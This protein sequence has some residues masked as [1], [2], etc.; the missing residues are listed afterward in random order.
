MLNLVEAEYTNVVY[1]KKAKFRFDEHNI[2]FVRGLNLDA[3]PLSPTGNGA[4]KSLLLGCPSNIF[5]FSPPLAIKKK[6]KK[7]L[8]LKGSKIRIVVKNGDDTFDVTQE[9]NKYT[10]LK[11][12]VDTEIRTVPLAEKL[13]REQIFTLSEL[14]YYTYGFVS[15]QKPFKMQSDSD[16]DRLI[17]FTA[18]FHLDNY[19][20]LRRHFLDK[21][22]ALKDSELT[23]QIYEKDHLSFS[24]KLKK[25]QTSLN[26]NIDL[27]AL[28][29][30][31]D[32]LELVITGLN[33]KEYKLRGF[34]RDLEVYS[35]IEEELDELRAKYTA[36]KAP[37]V[38]IKTLK[39]QRKLMR[40]YE[41][42]KKLFS[43]Y[44]STIKEASAKLKAL[45]LPSK[46][47]DELKLLKK[48][49][50]IEIDTLEH[51]IAD[52]KLELKQIARLDAELDSIVRALEAVGYKDKRPDLKVDH[53]EA[54]AALKTTLRL[55]K[56]IKHSHENKEEEG[57]CPTCLSELDIS[58]ISKMVEKAEK[59]LPKLEAEV[60]AQTKYRERKEIEKKRAVY[61]T[62]PEI[63]KSREEL[64]TKRE[65]N[66]EL[67]DAQ[68][69]TWEKHKSLTS[70]I[71]SIEKPEVVEK[72][73]SELTVD[74]FDAEIELCEEITK[75]L[76]SKEKLLE[77]SKD[78]S[79]LRGKKEVAI[80]ITA[81]K[82]E[83]KQLTKDLAHQKDLL[84]AVLREL[85]SNSSTKHECEVY[86]K[87]LKKLQGQISK[88]KPFIEDKQIFQ[89][90]AKAYSSKGL[91]TKV[92]NDICSLLEQN[93]NAY[94]SLIF[95][96]P[97]LFTVNASDK[98]ISILVDR[99]NGKISDVR[100][101]SGAESN[102]F[103]LLFV[104][105]LLPLVPDER[106]LN[107]LMLDEPC[108]H[109]DEISR[110][111]FLSIFL[112]ALAELVPNIFIITPNPE[113]YCEGS[114]DWIVKKENGKSILQKNKVQEIDV[115]QI[116]ASAK[117][118]ITKSRKSK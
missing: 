94:S 117:A 51:F 90:L 52:A 41:E 44:K 95:C 70:L 71:E 87:Q 29:K 35:T 25:A 110:N 86:E 50:S 118:A 14:D 11:N 28:S 2:V 93:L 77:S 46:D 48:K 58:D 38:Y 61:K 91:K 54:I 7:E 33:K 15:T 9:P 73:D 101:L 65:S 104:F 43:A 109:M 75:H 115:S 69:K 89:C 4:G 20:K 39:E 17:N 82:T 37:A 96:E 57:K 66:V 98:G 23:L 99:G 31:K 22:G 53:S 114:V 105:S 30:K 60:F 72:P 107:V 108:S 13:I 64:L 85:D 26:K 27:D 45:E 3:D 36:K 79:G 83:L 111:K 32:S 62:T 19:D 100:S 76:Q 24:S 88:L 92:A 80:K 68:L 78:L 18:M 103:R 67:I 21:L 16:T 40:A 34:L 42:Y 56:L 1:F 49:L 55:R 81:V 10:I 12:G 113:D 63:L 112:P 106:R 47:K 6:A 116:F 102:C 59:Q 97:F 8:L 5:F 84:S 74:Q